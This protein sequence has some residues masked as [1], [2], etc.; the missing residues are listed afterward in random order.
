[1]KNMIS[2]IKTKLKESQISI[3]G[4]PDFE[5]HSLGSS[6][7]GPPKRG[8]K[9]FMI[10]MPISKITGLF[11]RK[12]K[13]EETVPEYSEDQKEAIRRF[14]AGEKPY[15]SSGIDESITCGYGDLDDYGFWEF[16]LPDKY[17]KEKLKMNGGE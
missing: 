13:V 5:N 2:S 7:T 9:G 15:Y 8:I 10:S 6:V 12:I 14:K 4:P 1:M 11:K 16:P 17:W 3:E